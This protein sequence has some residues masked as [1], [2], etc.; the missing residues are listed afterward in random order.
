[1]AAAAEHAGDAVSPACGARRSAG[2]VT[3][4]AVEAVIGL[5]S[6]MGVYGP[7]VAR[8]ATDPQGKRI[9]GN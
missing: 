3:K 6:S 8:A 4:V 5:L 1:M 2:W 9:S 7:A